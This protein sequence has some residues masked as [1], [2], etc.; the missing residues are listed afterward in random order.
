MEFVKMEG[1][2]NDFVVVDNPGD[3][4]ETTVQAWC[5]RR[6]GVGAD[7]VLGVSEAEQGSGADIRMQYWNA[8]GSAA[9]MC[10]NG[11]R[12]V[13]RYAFD[14]SMVTDRTFIVATATGLNQVE[15]RDN[16]M[17]RAQLGSFAVGER[18]EIEGRT[19]HNVS[20][21]NP[22]AVTFVDEVSD[23]L[24]HGEGPVVETHQSFP[25]GVNVEFVRIHPN[26]LSMR[27][28]ERGVGETRACGT[29]AAAVAAVAGALGEVDNTVTVE[30]L[31]GNLDVELLG[32]Q[33]W[34]TGPAVYV[35]SG[36]LAG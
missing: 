34:I 25:D 11:L 13:A 18:I 29:G 1:L 15:I 32:H 7:G 5:D 21:G 8:D 19:Y 3:L 35:F 12:C 2:G 33:A 26:R 16:G 36:V 17:V 22:H 10:G 23:N 27:V 30:L 6:L 14:R 20:V 28:W 9:E 31:G 24:V 4:S